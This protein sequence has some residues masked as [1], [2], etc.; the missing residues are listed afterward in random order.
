[1][2]VRVHGHHHG[3]VPP[4]DPAGWL[5]GL[6]RLVVGDGPAR[7]GDRQVP[8]GRQGRPE[9]RGRLAQTGPELPVPR[10]PADG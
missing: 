6:R 1:M 2:G 9:E 10:Q 4:H 7:Q 5:Q 3:R 8:G